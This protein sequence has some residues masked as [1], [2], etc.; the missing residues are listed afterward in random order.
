MIACDTMVL[1]GILTEND[2]RDYATNS[3]DESG[4]YQMPIRR[5]WE[6]DGDVPTYEGKP[7]T[8]VAGVWLTQETADELDLEVA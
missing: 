2:N 3:N 4:R 7:M 6:S 1:L 8:R 5:Q